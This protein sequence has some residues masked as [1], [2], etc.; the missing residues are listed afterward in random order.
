MKT[1]THTHTQ[2]QREKYTSPF[3]LGMVK[4]K[5]KEKGY[6]NYIE[7]GV[8]GGRKRGNKMDK[9]LDAAEEGED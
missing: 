9:I 3:F 4:V 7:D 6:S 1:S 8:K 2:R 5:S